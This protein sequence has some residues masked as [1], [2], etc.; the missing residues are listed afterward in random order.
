VSAPIYIESDGHRA[1]IKW[2]RGRRRVTDPVFAGERILEAMRLGASVEIDLVVHGD[3]GFAVLHD[4]TLERETTGKGRVRDAS[5]AVLRELNLRGNDGEPIAEKVLLLEDLCTTLARHGAHSDALL[6]LDYKEDLSALSPE[7]IGHFAEITAPIAASLILS[8]GDFSAID[9][10]AK[11][12]PG[13][14]TGYDPCYGESLARLKATGDYHA[15][16]N[17]ALATAPDASMIYLDYRIV[18][19]AADIGIDLVAPVHTDGRKVDAWT[20]NHITP[21]SIVH[22]ERLLALNVDQ[23]TTDDPEGLAKAFPHDSQL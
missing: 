21:Q 2:H 17:Q 3:H 12:V 19:A 1:A 13:I 16:I 23:I 4:L 15:F 11:A 8:G 18:L 20:I 14:E 22:V 10:L 6:Q 9:S 5:A 7:V